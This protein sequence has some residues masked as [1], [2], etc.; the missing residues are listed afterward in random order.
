MYRG[1]EQEAC[2][3]LWLSLLRD[4]FARLMGA[5]PARARSY[6]DASD[7]EPVRLLLASGACPERE[8]Q[9]AC[10]RW[11]GSGLALMPCVTTTS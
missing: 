10:V 3:S 11:L 4:V 9:V 1:S 8:G 6:A 5:V 2:C 7:S